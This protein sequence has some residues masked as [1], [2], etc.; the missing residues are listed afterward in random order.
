AALGRRLAPRPAFQHQRDRQHPPRRPRI[1]RP[2]R[3][4]PQFL[5]RQ[6]GPGDRHRHSSLPNPRPGRANH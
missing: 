3:R 6:L 2:S 5:R 1:P 4:S